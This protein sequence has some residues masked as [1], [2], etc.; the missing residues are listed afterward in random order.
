MSDLKLHIYGGEG[1]RENSIYVHC[2]C[3]HSMR[4]KPRSWNPTGCSC[5]WMI[6]YT[7]IL[8]VPPLVRSTDRPGDLVRLGWLRAL[9]R[10]A[11]TNACPGGGDE[12]MSACHGYSTHGARK[13]SIVGCVLYSWS[14][15]IE[16]D[17]NYLSISLIRPL[18]DRVHIELGSST[19]SYDGI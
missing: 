18:I 11:V 7:T 14:S 1:T 10:A 6:Y 12:R 5:I 4:R 15:V 19:Q 13:E 17:E 16:L 9:H 2:T 8:Y 3:T